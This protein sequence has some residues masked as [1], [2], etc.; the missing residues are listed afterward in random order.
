MDECTQCKVL[1]VQ[2]SAQSHWAEMSDDLHEL[3]QHHESEHE[4]EDADLLA[5]LGWHGAV[6]RLSDVVNAVHRG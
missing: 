2:A 6:Q 5:L 1:V 4:G 3:I